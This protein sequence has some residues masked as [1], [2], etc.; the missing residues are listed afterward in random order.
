MNS[1][2]FDSMGSLECSF[3]F[4]Q[5]RPLLFFCKRA[6]EKKF[7]EKMAASNQSHYGPPQGGAQQSYYG[8]PGGMAQ[9]SMHGAQSMWG[10]PNPAMAPGGQTPAVKVSVFCRNLPKMDGLLGKSDPFL[11]VSVR[12]GTKKHVL[13]QTEVVKQD[14]NPTF[15]PFE[16]DVAEAGGEQAPLLWECYDWDSMFFFFSFFSYYCVFSNSFFLLLL[17]F[18]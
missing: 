11:I 8:P 18:F 13:F 2:N 14:L 4:S 5:I 12:R 9:Q 15:Q 16:I 3:G 17:N 7:V 6:R 1:L 10:A